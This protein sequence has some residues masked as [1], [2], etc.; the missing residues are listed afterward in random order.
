VLS[1]DISW[2]AMSKRRHPAGQWPAWVNYV[3]HYITNPDPTGRHLSKTHGL[4]LRGC[5]DTPPGQS[6]ADPLYVERTSGLLRHTL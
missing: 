3:K 5:T 2:V 6:L 1:H 4:L